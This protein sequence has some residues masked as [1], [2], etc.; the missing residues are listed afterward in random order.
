MSIAFNAFGIIL[1]VS[2]SFVVL[3]PVCIGVGGWGWPSSL[4]MWRIET[5]VFALMKRAPSSASVADD[6][7]A[8][9]IC[10]I[11]RTA[12]LFVGMSSLPAI[13]MCPPAW[14]HAFGSDK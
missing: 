8:H 2:R 5:T 4:C 6:M 1:L 9:I 3:L 13:N 14:L 10:E 7:T 12:Q 11:L